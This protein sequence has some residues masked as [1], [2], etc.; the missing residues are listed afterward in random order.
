MKLEKVV[1]VT[2]STYDNGKV[3]EM[4]LATYNEQYP[5]SPMQVLPSYGMHDRFLF[6]DDTAYHFGASLKD[7]GKNTFFFTQEDFT[8]DEVLKE[9]QKIQSEKESLAL[10][11]DNAD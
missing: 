9:S 7:L 11:D 5:D 4:G 6:I 10:Q 2:I 1:S 3:L 8:L